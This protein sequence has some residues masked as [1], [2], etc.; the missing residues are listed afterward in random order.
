MGVEKA[1]Q[2]KRRCVQPAFFLPSKRDALDPSSV[3]RHLESLV[4]CSHLFGPTLCAPNGLAW[5]SNRCNTPTHNGFRSLTHQILKCGFFTKE[6]PLCRENEYALHLTHRKRRGRSLA[7]P[8]NQQDV[9]GTP[10]SCRKS[11]LCS[12]LRK[13]NVLIDSSCPFLISTALQTTNHDRAASKERRSNPPKIDGDLGAAE[14]RT[15]HF[16]PHSP[17]V[18]VVGRYNSSR[19]TMCECLKLRVKKSLCLVCLFFVRILHTIS[20]TV[21]D[22]RRFTEVLSAKRPPTLP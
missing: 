7:A 1:T 5:P 13:M 12:S 11:M 22:V 4:F 21:A 6:H 3:V 2:P 20:L 9:N 14:N 8:P 16:P 19:Q 17:T 15:S 18:W 10:P